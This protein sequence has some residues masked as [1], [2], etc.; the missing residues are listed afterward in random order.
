[1]K[2]T[3]KLFA[4]LKEIVGSGEVE[5][6]LPEGADVGDLL[7]KLSKDYGADFD[8][9]VI[10]DRTRRVR[11]YLQIVVDGKY[12]SFSEKRGIRLR[13]GSVVAI[14]PPIGGG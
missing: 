3:V 13:D 5:V 2:V 8:N 10:D 12:T 4:T 7:E 9:Y 14:L 6:N 11:R 1:M